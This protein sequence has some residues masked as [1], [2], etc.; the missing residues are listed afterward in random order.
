MAGLFF[1]LAPAEGAGLLFF[2]RQRISHAQAF[3]VAFL[4]SMQ[5]YT[6]KTSK[7]FTGLYSGFTVDL[8]YSSA[9]NTADT[10]ADYTPPAP[11]WR[12]YRQAL[13]LHRYQIPPP[14]RTLYR[15]AQ[16]PYYNK[17]YIRVQ[18]CAL[19][20]IHAR[21][22][23]IAQT[24]PARRGQL[25]PCADRWQVLTACQQYRPGAPAEGSASPPVQG[26]PGGLLPGIDGQRADPTA[27]GR[28]H[29][30]LAAAALFG[31]SPDS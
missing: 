22:C 29:W 10:Q 11:R 4:P 23:S 30:R 15:S 17:V 1:C 27:G 21:Q 7:A 13:H 14:R 8:P 5:N 9:H 25:L 6:T 20:W 2:V 16:P 18:G 26:Q 31:L 19:L 12:A 24:M 28:N 3:T